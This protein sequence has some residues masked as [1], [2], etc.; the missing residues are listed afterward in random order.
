MH[1]SSVLLQIDRSSASF[2]ALRKPLRRL[3]RRVTARRRSACRIPNPDRVEVLLSGAFVLW[4]SR[5]LFTSE[6]RPN[7]MFAREY[8]GTLVVKPYSEVMAMVA[9]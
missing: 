5:Y 7:R 8:L 9:E 1:P 3:E 6:E 2:V 4:G